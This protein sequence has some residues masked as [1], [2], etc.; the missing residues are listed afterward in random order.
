VREDD[1]FGLSEAPRPL[2]LPCLEVAACIYLKMGSHDG[3]A[4]ELPPPPPVPPNV[5]PIKADD[6]LGES[7][8]NK[9]VKPKKL[10]MVRPGVGRK[11][12]PI[13]LY[14]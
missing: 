1:D 8:P 3:E 2:L 9:P 13:Q 5:V 11:G 14:S 6:V 10:P 4:D 12:Q 7:P